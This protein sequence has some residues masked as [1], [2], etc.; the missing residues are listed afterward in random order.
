MR[1]SKVRITYNDIYIYTY[2]YIYIM[3][4]VHIDAYID[5]E[6]N[7]LMNKYRDIHVHE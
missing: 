2:I 1:K 7:T 6:I 4:G 3:T 5:E